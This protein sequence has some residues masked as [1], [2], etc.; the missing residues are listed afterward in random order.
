VPA[1]LEVLHEYFLGAPKGT[2]D[3]FTAAVLW[4]LAVAAARRL[5]LGR[6]P[7]DHAFLMLVMGVD[8]APGHL[9]LDDGER[10]LAWW[11]RP[12]NARLATMQ[13]RLMHDVATALDGEMRL[14]P[15]AT[16]RQR[17]VTVH[18][19]G[20]CAM[21]DQP[22]D[23]VT[24]ANGK[25]W[26]TRALYVL[27][28]A[29]IPGTLGANPSATI[30][31]IAERNVRKALEDTSSPIHTPEIVPLDPP[32]PGGP[33]LA[34][35]RRQLGQTSRVLDPIAGITDPAPPPQAP[36]LG[37]R[38]EEVMQG[39]YRRSTPDLLPIGARLVATID[40]LSAF[41]VDPR[42]PVTISGT[43]TLVPAPGQREIVY[44]A[45]GTL[46]LLRRV[47]ASSALETLVAEGL[48][49][50]G[51]LTALRHLP[52]RDQRRQDA[53]DR[54]EMLVSR[55]ET[56]VHRYEMDYHLALRPHAGAGAGLRL[57]G[58]KTIHGGPG[59]APW[60]QTTT[61]DVTIHAAAPP[62]ASPIGEGRMHVH[63]AD[64]LGTQLPSF[65]ITGTNDPT[66]IAWALARFFRFFLGTLR[67]VYLPQ[68]EMLD[69]LADRAP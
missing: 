33:S 65:A 63:L 25:V 13:E 55:L 50:L 67:Q 32:L 21:A 23:G 2:A 26:G 30:A 19:L 11:D 39:S 34:D 35:I 16:S 3:P 52:A 14:N 24:D 47:E 60:T 44:D 61:L 15:D 43:V 42:R 9:Y 6:R 45:Q 40:D 41:L 12:A 37:L 56:Q 5:F 48:E 17:P 53:E 29:A 10:L 51:A 7:D 49:R 54:L 27:D 28:G 4:P 46:N 64:L 22:E 20:G 31:A 8:A 62:N 58:V 36:A 66:R 69:P 38:F 68:L 57:E 1:T 59:L 18:N